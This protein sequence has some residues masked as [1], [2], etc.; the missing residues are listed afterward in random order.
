MYLLLLSAMYLLFRL[1]KTQNID[2]GNYFYRLP[3]SFLPNFLLLFRHRQIRLSSNNPDD[4]LYFL[5]PISFLLLFFPSAPF[6]IYLYL[7]LTSFYT[8]ILFTLIIFGNV[9]GKGDRC[10]FILVGVKTIIVLG[11]GDRGFFILVSVKTI[12]LVSRTG[13]G[14]SLYWFR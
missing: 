2:T 13:I 1:I 10:F 4:I 11:K 5:F 8:Q 9:L 6:I 12:I 3:L 14:G 7:L